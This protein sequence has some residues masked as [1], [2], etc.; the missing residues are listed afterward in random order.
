MSADSEERAR[1]AR[2]S[3]GLG[4]LRIGYGLSQ[5][6]A[7]DWGLYIS[8]PIQNSELHPFAEPATFWVRPDGVLY[9]ATYNTTP[10]SRAHWTDWL[11]ALDAIRARDYPPRGG[12]RS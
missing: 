2:H 10:F 4:A 3:W 9:A 1:E 7:K 6:A 11:E 5:K 8:D 12:H